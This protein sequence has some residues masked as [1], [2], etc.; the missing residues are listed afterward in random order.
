MP[1]QFTALIRK[2]V[3]GYTAHCLEVDVMCKG[4]TLEEARDGLQEALERYLKNLPPEKPHTISEDFFLLKI[5]AG[6]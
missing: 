2:E 1:R 4:K 5:E 3:D 6:P